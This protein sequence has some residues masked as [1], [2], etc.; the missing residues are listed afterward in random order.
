MNINYPL[1]ILWPFEDVDIS[2]DNTVWPDFQLFSRFKHEWF[3]MMK[4]TRLVNTIR[5]LGAYF[6]LMCINP[7]EG[8]YEYLVFRGIFNPGPQSMFFEMPTKKLYK[9][10]TEE[11]ASIRRW[12]LNKE[13][14][15]YLLK[16]QLS[17]FQS[18]LFTFS[19][20]FLKK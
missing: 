4:Q 10:Y 3:H 15:S 17:V 5:F 1:T 7:L 14:S 19:Y 2:G 20:P 16:D 12:I 11:I 6:V 8:N 18:N 13:T 9:N